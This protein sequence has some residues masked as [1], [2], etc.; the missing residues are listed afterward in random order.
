MISPQFV[1]ADRVIISNLTNLKSFDPSS[2]STVRFMAFA[3]L[4]ACPASLCELFVT[5]ERSL[6]LS[7][8]PCPL[9]KLALNSRRLNGQSLVTVRAGDPPRPER[10]SCAARAVRSP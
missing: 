1:T 7:K 10:L 3:E 9:S 2:R 5:E 6:A 4:P 8:G